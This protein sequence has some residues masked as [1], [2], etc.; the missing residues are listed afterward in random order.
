MNQKEIIKAVGV[1]FLFLILSGCAERVAFEDAGAMSTVG[2]WHGLWHGIIAPVAW[3]ISLFNKEVTIYAIHN[4]GAFYN[5]GFILGFGAISV[6]Y[7]S[8]KY[9]RTISIK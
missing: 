7:K 5:L 8:S 3:I 2:F 1:A 6:G 4:N 9:K